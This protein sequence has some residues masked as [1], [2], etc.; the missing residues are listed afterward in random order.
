MTMMNQGFPT[1][2]RLVS[3]KWLYS[4]LSGFIY[5]ALS[6]NFL[7]VYYLRFMREHRYD[8]NIGPN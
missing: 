2:R 8:N 3:Q 5:Q 7:G 1:V 4:D 6:W